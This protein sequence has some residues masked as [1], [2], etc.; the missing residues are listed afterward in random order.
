MMRTAK[1][2]LFNSIVIRFWRQRANN[3]SQLNCSKKHG[4]QSVHQSNLEETSLKHVLSHD[5]EA[6]E[7][8]AFLLTICW[9]RCHYG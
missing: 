2:G 3:R 1:D 8:G 9:P 4:L 7:K 6:L 5:V